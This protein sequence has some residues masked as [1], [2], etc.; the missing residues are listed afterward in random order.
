M[1]ILGA[2][3][4]FETEL[5]IVLVALVPVLSHPYQRAQI[6]PGL[7]VPP[8]WLQPVEAVVVL[9]GVTSCQRPST[10]SYASG[11]LSCRLR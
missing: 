11:R 2:V 8:L 7:P 3:E 6:Q 5:V 9:W 10:I 1:A 4:S